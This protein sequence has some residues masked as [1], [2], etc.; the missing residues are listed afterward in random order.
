MGTVALGGIVNVMPM[1]YGKIES[2][3]SQVSDCVRLNNYLLW[4]YEI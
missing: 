2:T 4:L 1:L 3:A